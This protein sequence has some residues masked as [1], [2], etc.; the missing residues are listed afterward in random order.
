MSGSI[1]LVVTS[2]SLTQATASGIPVSRGHGRQ[3]DRPVAAI[4]G[5]DR[6]S[7]AHQSA[8][9]RSGR[10][11]RKPRNERQ[12]HRRDRG[13]GQ[14]T[15]ALQGTLT[16]TVSGGVATFSSLADDLVGAI[17][18]GFT[19]TGLTSAV[20]VPITISPATASKLV[21]QTPPSST[22]TAGQAFPTTPSSMKKTSSATW[23]RVT[24]AR[25][26][27]R[28]SRAAVVRSRDDGHRFRWRRDVR[29]P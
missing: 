8:R 7:A 23:R 5:R 10:S 19:G 15:G 21:I 1:S 20:S 3:A 6:R 16:A 13:P 27:R 9:D 2:G 25:S 28:R 11:V 26:S 18:I 4:A 17:T 29:Q 14:R 24:T 12:Q 22:A